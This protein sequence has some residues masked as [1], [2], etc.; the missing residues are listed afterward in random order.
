VRRL[1]ER[2]EK[3]GTHFKQAQVDV[4]QIRIST[5]GIARHG[6]RIRAV[7]LGEAKTPGEAK[8]DLLTGEK[9]GSSQPPND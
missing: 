3:L 1:D 2:V 7:D 8:A 5:E 6:E 4:D 9:Q